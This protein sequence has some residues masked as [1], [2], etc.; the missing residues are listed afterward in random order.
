MNSFSNILTLA[1]SR[2]SDLVSIKKSII[3]AKQNNGHI[4]VLST[5]KKN[6][7]YHQWLNKT[8]NN[9]VDNSEKIQRLVVFAKQQGVAINYKIR[10]EKDKFVALKKQLE[11]QQYDLIVAEHQKEES[12]L[13]PFDSTEYSNLLNTSDISILF[14]GDYKW[15]VNGN[16]LAAIETEENT[17]NHHSFNDEII[18]KTNEL[19]MLLKSNIHFFNCY[20]KNCGISFK[21]K[22]PTLEFNHHLNNLNALVKAHHFKDENLHI[23]EGLVDDIIPNQANR[24]GAN[25]VVIGC[26][27]HKG[28][29]SKIKGHTIDYVLDDLDCDILALKQSIH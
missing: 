28:W 24:F 19:A 20:L 15:R 17:L 21:E 23:E 26:G 11:G 12:R 2:T 18:V 25:V 5:R 4:T 3:L 16:V 1:E 7:S 8:E 29:L 22:M 10:E 9:V 14:V 13:W 27:E 6:S